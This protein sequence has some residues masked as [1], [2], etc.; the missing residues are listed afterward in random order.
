VAER[1]NNRF[2]FG[3]FCS[4]FPQTSLFDSKYLA[5]LSFWLLL[6]L[7]LLLLL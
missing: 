6:L 2:F 3:F 5:F 1:L 4:F 7:L